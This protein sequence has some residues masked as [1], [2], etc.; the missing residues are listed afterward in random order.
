MDADT[1]AKY[2]KQATELIL[3]DKTEQG[4]PSTWYLFYSRAKK[5]L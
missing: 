1:L 3:A 5:P 4:I 2:K